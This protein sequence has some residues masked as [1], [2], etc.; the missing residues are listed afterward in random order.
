MQYFAV[1]DQ[2]FTQ[3]GLE[4]S[5]SKRDI[6]IL[7][8]SSASHCPRSRWPETKQRK[9]ERASIGATAWVGNNYFYF[10]SN[11][12]YVTSAKR[13]TADFSYE[14]KNDAI[15]GIFREGIPVLFLWVIYLVS[16]GHCWTIDSDSKLCSR[17]VVYEVSSCFLLLFIR[18]KYFGWLFIAVLQ[19]KSQV[20][21]GFSPESV[22]GALLF[23]EWIGNV[24][25]F[26]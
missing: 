16:K 3:S 4:A 17:A 8:F 14:K 19:C 22:I 11:H 2:N 9:P 24:P 21:V 12:I 26:V 20:K 15:F 25:S 13:H 23:I 18:W 1:N 6:Q 7:L 10:E 5:R